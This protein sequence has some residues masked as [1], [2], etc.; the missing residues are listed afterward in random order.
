MRAFILLLSLIAAPALAEERWRAVTPQDS[1]YNPELDMAALVR[2]DGSFAV[3]IPDPDGPGAMAGFGILAD[4]YSDSITSVLRIGS[5]RVSTREVALPELIWQ[6]NA[7]DG[8]VT[9]LFPISPDEVELF[10]A[11]RSWR[12]ILGTRRVEF[13]L[14]GSR[15]AIDAAEA[16][17]AAR[18]KLLQSIT[19]G[20]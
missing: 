20:G 3:I 6:G 5:G 9:Y 15:V 1:M 14:T 10:K 13:P 11:G 8:A 2:A 7:L 19:E 18:I 16:R 17:K 12:I 4:G